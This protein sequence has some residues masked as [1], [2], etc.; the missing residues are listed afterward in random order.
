MEDDRVAILEAQLSQAKLIAEESDKKYEEVNACP[1]PHYHTQTSQ[2][3]SEY[4][5]DLLI[6]TLTKAKL[7]KSLSWPE[8][9]MWIPKEV[10]KCLEHIPLRY[11]S[12]VTSKRS[13]EPVMECD[14]KKLRLQ[15]TVLL[16]G[17][18]SFPQI[19]IV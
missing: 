3:D 1:S 4:H 14:V 5:T 15:L 16:R 11:C 13:A 10:Q 7:F 12:D 19:S 18:S 8:S 17:S 2:M 9:Y 6:N